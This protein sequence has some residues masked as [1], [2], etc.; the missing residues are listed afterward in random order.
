MGYE[1]IIFT[2]SENTVVLKRD[3]RTSLPTAV[4]RSLSRKEISLPL[5]SAVRSPRLFDSTWLDMS[6]NVR[7][8]E[9]RLSAFSKK[10]L[11][12]YYHST[13]R[14]TTIAQK[15]KHSVLFA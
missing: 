4:L 5:V 11:L 14:S 13:C 1:E 15:Y 9:K 7:R 8:Q 12:S 6:P 10:P 3:T 2:I